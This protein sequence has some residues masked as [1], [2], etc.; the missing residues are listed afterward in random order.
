MRGLDGKAVLMAGGAGGIGSATSARLG[1]EGVRVAVGDLDLAAAEAVATDINR[2]G[3]EAF[4][5]RLDIGDEDSVVEAVQ[6]AV[7]AFGGLDGVH[8]NAADLSPETI[9][10]D[11]DAQTIDLDAF[12]RTIRTNLRGHLLCTR[13]ALPELL[14]RGGGALVYTSSAAA[15]VGEPERPAY[16]V[17]KSG[18]NAI[19]RHVAS[20][21]GKQGVRA[22]AVAPGLVLTD[23]I[24]ESLDPSFRDMALRGSRSPRL[25]RPD[26]IAAMVAFLMSSDAEWI[27][28]Q[29]ISVDGGATMR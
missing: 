13:H 3:G 22:N 8:V 24:Q 18:I 6:A 11:T 4:A 12:D 1:A 14:Q 16:A 9:T 19:V 26:D 29:V 28:G 20:K 2:S 23:R 7:K 10:A 27:N 15:F 5:I 25:G 17:A 21:W